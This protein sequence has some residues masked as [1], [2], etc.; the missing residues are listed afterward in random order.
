MPIIFLV[1]F[2]IYRESVIGH[3]LEKGNLVARQYEFARL[4]IDPDQ[5][6]TRWAIYLLYGFVKKAMSER[7]T[8]TLAH[9]L[10]H[11]YMRLKGVSHF[12][13]IIRML[14]QGKSDFEIYQKQHEELTGFHELFEEPVRSLILKEEEEDSS[15][16][17]RLAKEYCRNSRA[18]SDQGFFETIL[19]AEGAK[20][21]LE[22]ETEEEKRK[23]GL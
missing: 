17:A 1:D 13:D 6:K 16:F 2:Y 4:S 11:F 9:E 19:G 8:A 14:L 12:Q 22:E 7:V 15:S 18:L 23:L 5:P 20:K 21:Y 10:T 3:D